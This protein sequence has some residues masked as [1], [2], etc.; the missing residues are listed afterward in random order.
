VVSVR[1]ITDISPSSAPTASCTDPN[2]QPQ[3]AAGRHT[4]QPQAGRHTR[5]PQ[6]G[7]PGSRGRQAHQ[8]AAG[9]HTRQ[10]QGRALGCVSVTEGSRGEGQGKG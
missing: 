6:A 2:M 9:R 7:T 1:D 10:P 5:Q 8:A 4:R 3:A